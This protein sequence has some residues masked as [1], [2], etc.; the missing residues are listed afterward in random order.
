[1]KRSKVK[2]V[3]ERFWE[4]VVIVER[5]CWQW[6]ASMT[7][8]GYGQFR[9]FGQQGAHRISWI[10]HH[11]SIPRGGCV[12]HRCGSR[13]CA[14]PK[15]LYIGSHKDNARDR[16]ADGRTCH[17]YGETNGKAKLNTSAVIEIRSRALGGES[18][19]SIAR[20]FSV[21]PSLISYVVRRKIWSHV[22]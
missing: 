11:G 19:D 21:S 8:H 16:V 10:L 2:S 12:L 20:R 14:N 3:S 18:Q 9:G 13:I 22:R 6:K 1:M 5:G 7:T 17:M 15:H 4:K